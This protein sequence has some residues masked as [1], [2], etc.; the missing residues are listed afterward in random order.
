MKKSFAAGEDLEAHRRVTLSGAT[1]IYADAEHRGIGVTEYAVSSGDYVTV[2]LDNAGGTVEVTADGAITAGNDIFPADDG[3]V[4]ATGSISIG[5]CLETTTAD[6]DVF[7][8]IVLSDLSQA[9]GVESE[10]TGGAGGIT[11]L[12]LVYVSDQTAGAMTVLKA[13]ATSGGRF[14]DFICPEAIA[15]ASKGLALKQYLL[16]GIDTSAGSVGDPVY[17]SDG[18]AGGYTLTKPTATD[19]VQIIGRI[20]EDDAS[21]GA[22]LF[23]L[24]GPQQVVHDHSSNAEGGSSL[25]AHTSDTI[26]LN[27]AANIAA[28]TSTGSK[29]GTSASQKLA[30]WN[31]TPVVQPS[32]VADPAACASMTATLT[33]V[34]TGTDMTAAQAATIVADLAALKTAIDANNA[35]IDSILD[36][37]ATIGAQAAS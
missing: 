6:G 22:I 7:E 34:D 17:L 20:V 3:K 36:Q 1:V 14:A 23:D 29:I 28:N 37:L 8:A 31:A 24:S 4:S 13:Q 21:T 32:H 26:T 33:G 19:K 15:A 25:G 2:R 18:T 16:Q 12:D 10:V 11:A 27:D 5:K 30:L 35:A 9:G